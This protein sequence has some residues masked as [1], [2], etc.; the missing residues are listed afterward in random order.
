MGK[1]FT[2]DDEP[3]YKGTLFRGEDPD[4]AVDGEHVM[5]RNHMS[6]SPVYATLIIKHIKDINLIYQRAYLLPIITEGDPILQNV[7]ELF[8]W[9]VAKIDQD[10]GGYIFGE[11]CPGT[12]WY[13]GCFY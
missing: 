9:V 10:G 3:K 11:N 4:P 2:I 6:Y 7:Q 8:N 5:M 12:S 13:K 1:A